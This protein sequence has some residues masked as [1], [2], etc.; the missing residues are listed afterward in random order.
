MQFKVFDMRLVRTDN[1]RVV[2]GEEQMAYFQFDASWDNSVKTAG[3]IRDGDVVYHAAIVDGACYVPS[4]LMDVPSFGVVVFRGGMRKTNPVEIAVEPNPLACASI[5]PPSDLYGDL[6]K[7]LLK[8]EEEKQSQGNKESQHIAD[9]QNPHGVTKEQ[10][11]LGHVDDTADTDKPL[12]HAM[13]KALEKKADKEN[14]LLIGEDITK[15]MCYARFTDVYEIDNTNAIPDAKGVWGTTAT[16]IPNQLLHVTAE[17][18]VGI[19]LGADLLSDGEEAAIHCDNT[20]GMRI[21][22]APEVYYTNEVRAKYLQLVPGD[23]ILFRRVGVRT[24]LVPQKSIA[25]FDGTQMTIL[26]HLVHSRVLGDMI[27]KNARDFL[28]KPV[29]WRCAYVSGEFYAEE[30]ERYAIELCGD[31]TFVLPGKPVG[32]AD[33]CIEM[34]LNSP[35]EYKVSFGDVL[36]PDG[37]ALVLSYGCYR[38]VCV[39]DFLYGKWCVSATEYR[40]DWSEA[41]G[42]RADFENSVFERLESANGKSKGADFDGYVMYGGRKRCNVADDG[43]ILAYEGDDGYVTDGSN[44][45]VMVYQPAFYYKVIPLILDGIKIRKAEYYVSEKPLAGFKRHPAFYDKNGN[46]IDYILLSAFEGCVYDADGG[47]DGTGAYVICE[48]GQGIGYD[49]SADASGSDF[50]VDK[51]SSIAGTVP[52]NNITRDQTMQLAKNRGEGWHID[53]ILSLSMHQLLMVIEGGTF[54]TRAVY[55]S[56]VAYAGNMVPTGSTNSNGYGYSHFTYRGVEAVW[57]NTNKHIGGVQFD[58]NNAFVVESEYSASDKKTLSQKRMGTIGYNSAFGYHSDADWL[59]IPA[60]VKGTS[61]T[62]MGDQSYQRH[63]ANA[64]VIFGMY[65]ALTNNTG[66]FGITMEET[67]GGGRL[68]YVPTAETEDES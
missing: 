15:E 8:L 21:N 6:N 54:R 4:A 7:R 56:G 11:G 53:H 12:S 10:V 67:T 14:F 27:Y 37:K 13:Q 25:F 63:K 31:C 65:K 24:Y 35:Y 3:F 20:Q 49:K 52:F 66:A 68:L 55:G 23:I 30:N 57:G 19:G 38:I 28:P 9:S 41:L 47:E 46:A 61:A 60:E 50:S 64:Y 26:P 44:G 5:L 40:E 17:G 1:E 62:P 48:Q 58:E 34:I 22:I 32:D 18:Y 59:F 36:Y 16:I 51:L 39:Y 33:G 2:Q 43:T 45:Q 29:F 42:L